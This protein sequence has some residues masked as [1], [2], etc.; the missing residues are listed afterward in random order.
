MNLLRTP[1]NPASL[2]RRHPHCL[3]FVDDAA[4]ALLYKER[5]R[6]P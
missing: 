4:G 3:L 2:L 5:S 1:F 6:T